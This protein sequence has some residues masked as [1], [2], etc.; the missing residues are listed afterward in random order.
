MES[1]SC[2]R[3]HGH[4]CGPRKYS[5]NSIN[6]DKFLSVSLAPGRPSSA[7]IRKGSTDYST[8]AQQTLATDNARPRLESRPQAHLL[9]FSKHSDDYLL[10]RRCPQ[11]RTKPLGTPALQQR[12]SRY[13]VIL[14]NGRLLTQFNQRKSQGSLF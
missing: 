6:L 2:S 3:S 4:P 13:F 8:N 11:R 5:V 7:K 1:R 12:L 14:N 10:V 9:T